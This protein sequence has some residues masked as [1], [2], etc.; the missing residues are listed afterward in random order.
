[1]K[2]NILTRETIMYRKHAKENAESLNKRTNCVPRYTVYVFLA[3]EPDFSMVS[4]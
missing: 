1:M 3:T 4:L 2:T